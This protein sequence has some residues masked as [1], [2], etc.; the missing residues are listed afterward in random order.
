[1]IA[2]MFSFCCSWGRW[3]DI[4][5]HANWKRHMEEKDVEKVSRAIVSILLELYGCGF[6]DI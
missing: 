1:M 4:V 2:L 5:C 3:S 6:G